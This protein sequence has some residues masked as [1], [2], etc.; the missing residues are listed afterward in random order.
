MRRIL[1]EPEREA[2][3]APYTAQTLAPIED[4]FR[5]VGGNGV[6]T[7]Q[8]LADESNLKVPHSTLTRFIGFLCGSFWQPWVA[9]VARRLTFCDCLSPSCAVVPP[10]WSILCERSSPVRRSTVMCQAA[11]PGCCARRNTGSA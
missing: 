7:E 5:L 2:D 9:S 8:L 6:R 4:A 11:S 1:C 3:A 10:R